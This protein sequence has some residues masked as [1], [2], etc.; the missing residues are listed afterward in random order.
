MQ[1]VLSNNKANVLIRKDYILISFNRK[2]P[3]LR[4]EF[5]ELLVHRH[6]QSRKK[7]CFV[8]RHIPMHETQK[9]HMIHIAHENLT[10][11]KSSK[12]LLT[13]YNKSKEGFIKFQF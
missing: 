9:K 11:K 1:Q 10:F 4:H 5:I 3:F 13:I 2:H 8:F 7:S 12:T 6:F